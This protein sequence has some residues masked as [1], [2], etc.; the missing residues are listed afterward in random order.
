SIPLCPPEGDAGTGMVATN[1]VAPRTGNVS[2]GTSIFAM[3]VLEGPLVRQHSELDLVT[4]PAGDLVAMV[5]CN[6]GASELN[7]WAGLFGEF[8]TALGVPTE[9][10]TVFGTLFRAALDGED[11]AAGLLA[12]NYLSGEPITGL[13]EGRPLFVR[14]PGSSLSLPNFMRAQLFAAFATLRVGMDVLLKEEGV[15]L[16]AMF[17]HGGLFRTKGVAQRFLAGAIGSP[18]TVGEIAGEGGAW[19]IAVLAAFMKGKAPEQAL[20][21]Y[22]ASEVFSGSPLETVDPDPADVAGFDAFMARWTAGL[23]VERA[24]VASV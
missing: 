2:A 17:A 12:Y 5:H 9:D 11:D 6:N 16:D 15:R 19:G 10:A 1:S 20:G 23:D 22:L 13:D 21:D 4:T 7:A 3:V 14:T 18:V 8:A 24:A